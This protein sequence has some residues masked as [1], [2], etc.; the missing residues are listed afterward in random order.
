MRDLDKKKEENNED[1]EM[2]ATTLFGMEELLEK[3]LLRLG[4]KNIKPANR[5]VSFEGDKGFLYKANL[6]LR[7]A[8]KILVPVAE[9][10]AKTDQQLYDGMSNIDFSQFMDK[11]DTLAIFSTINS[12]NF[13]HTQYVSQK[14]KDAIVDQ[15]RKK[16]GTRPSVDL[17]R[18]TVKFYVH[19]FRDEVTLFLDSSGPSLYKRGYRED[20][21]LAPLNEVLAAGMV[22]LSGW[23][24]HIPLLDPMC[25]SGTILTEA[26]MIANNIPPG[27]YR[28][29]YGFMRWKDYDETLWDTIYEAAI[30]K[31]TDHKLNLI[32]CDISRNVIKKAKENAKSAKLDDEIKFV[33][34]DFFDY[35]PE[36]E[37]GFI[38]MNPPYG[39]RMD[40]DGDMKDFYKKIGDK[41]KKDFTNFTAWMISSDIEALKFVG[42]RPTRKIKLFNGALEC[43]FN[44]FELYSGSKKDMYQNKEE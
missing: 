6:Q 41:F 25:G 43:R 9:F 35:T 24:R 5:A 14:T 34:S 23:E 36:T 17:Q 1:F 42:L 21:N 8:M 31:I 11:D 38:I 27:Y 10:Y 33:A 29:E 22:M 28:Q 18:P 19:I 15:F 40:K 3:E 12:D 4:A 26:A 2:I 7:T 39:E 30:N 20:T 37:R 32:G 13:N 16:V 44:K